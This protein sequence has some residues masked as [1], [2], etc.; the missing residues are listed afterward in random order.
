MLPELTPEELERYKR[1]MKMPGFG[2]EAQRKLKGSSALVTRIGGLGGPTALYLAMA[3]IGKLT[4]AHGG[5]ITPSNLNRQ[6]LMR[7]DAV[8]EPRATVAA[9]TLTRICPHVEVSAVCSNA[10]P[11]NVA[12]L[13]GGVDLVCDTTPDFGERRLLNRECVKQ[14]KPLVDS[15]MNDWECQLTVVVPGNTAC[16]ECLIPEPPEWWEPY[17]FGVLGGVC[18]AL[19]CLTA[20]EAIKL[21]TGCG[22]SLAGHLLAFDLD[23]LSFHKFEARRRSDCP[24][25]GHL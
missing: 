11:E 12:E 6:L 2:V 5:A 19:G 18:G 24:V 25:C 3:G 10:T 20:I 16:L 22:T 7:G 8:G 1:Q 15:G 23:E 4:I 9:E 14:G 21:L 13:V 17:G